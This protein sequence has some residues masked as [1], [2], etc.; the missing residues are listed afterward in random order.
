MVPPR[1][2]ELIT[3]LNE[4]EVG[5]FELGINQ[6]ADHCP[7]I[8]HI[9]NRFVIEARDLIKIRRIENERHCGVVEAVWYGKLVKF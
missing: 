9:W 7:D 1:E 2:S 8:I 4:P 5:H 3:L 6:W